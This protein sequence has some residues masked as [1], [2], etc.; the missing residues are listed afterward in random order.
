MNPGDLFWE[1]LI[2]VGNEVPCSFHF[3]WLGRGGAMPLFVYCLKYQ[4]EV[5]NECSFVLCVSEWR[6]PVK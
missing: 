3:F 4:C 6:M 2:N 1:G 5:N